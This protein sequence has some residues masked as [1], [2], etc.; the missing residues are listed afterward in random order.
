VQIDF[1]R[2]MAGVGPTVKH[3]LLLAEFGRYPI[4]FHW[5][6]LATRF[7]LKLT[8][9][10]EA[11]AGRALQADVQ[12]M[13]QGCKACWSYQLLDT[14]SDLGV[15]QR[16]QWL[17]GSPGITVQGVLALQPEPDDVLAALCAKADARLLRTLGP[18]MTPRDP[19]VSQDDILASTYVNW[20]RHPQRPVPSYLASTQLSFG[21]LQSICR[22]RLGWHRLEVQQGRFAKPKVPR[23]ERHCK[24]CKAL[25]CGE[26]VEDLLQR[27]RESY[28]RLAVGLH[29]GPSRRLG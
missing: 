26:Y 7:W 4:M 5:V 2:I 12:L 1:L 16:Q 14:W 21:Q 8:A 9:Q 23:Q 19:A 13:L 20:V 10:P 3:D 11:V 24:L 6:K 18:D 29:P 25:G 15:V 17:P 27:E 28:A 22:L